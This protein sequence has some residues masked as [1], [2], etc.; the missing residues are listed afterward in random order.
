MTK[1]E[2]YYS[3]DTP[4]MKAAV[5]KLAIEGVSGVTVE[6][7]AIHLIKVEAA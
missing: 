5:P 1:V 4:P 2:I 3:P 7:K 6:I